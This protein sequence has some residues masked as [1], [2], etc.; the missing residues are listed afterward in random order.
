MKYLG[1]NEADGNNTEEENEEAESILMSQNIN[2]HEGLLR[3]NSPNQPSSS[4]LN[5]EIYNQPGPSGYKR[6][7][8]SGTRSI[9]YDTEY[10]SF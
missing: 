10:V 7:I 9:G 8:S 2:I 6:E 3:V 5:L 4:G 1:L